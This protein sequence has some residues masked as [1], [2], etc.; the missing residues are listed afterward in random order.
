MCAQLDDLQKAYDREPVWILRRRLMEKIVDHL[1]CPVCIQEKRE[2]DAR[3]MS[4]AK[5][6]RG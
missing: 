6:V 4:A 5:G 1:T 2:I 3:V